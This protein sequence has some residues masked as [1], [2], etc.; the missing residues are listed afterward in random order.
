MIN[1][2]FVRSHRAIIVSRCRVKPFKALRKI[3]F[4]LLPIAQTKRVSREQL[5]L[6]TN[7]YIYLLNCVNIKTIYFKQ[8]FIQKL[9]FYI[10]CY[11][12]SFIFF[13]SAFSNS[14]GI[15]CVSGNYVFQVIF[16]LKQV[17]IIYLFYIYCSLRGTPIDS[18]R[19]PPPPPKIQILL[20][21]HKRFLRIILDSCLFLPHGI[22]IPTSSN[23][24]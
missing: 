11:Q 8:Y 1:Q 15:I 13:I 18:I 9:M 7:I 21:K 5:I 4:S 23:N 14:K 2:D 3:L 19:P 22:P 16:S 24:Y 17:F 20:V 12:R 6:S 10:F